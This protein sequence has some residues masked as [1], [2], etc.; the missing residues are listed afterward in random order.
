VLCVL[1]NT[2][3]IP[4]NGYVLFFVKRS[5]KI[6]RKPFCLMACVLVLG[7]AG[8]VSADLVAHLEFEDNLND[9]AGGDNGGTFYGGSASYVTGQNPSTAPITGGQSRRR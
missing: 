9:S 3:K 7:L 5:K 6:L 4:V 1:P 2:T 8:S